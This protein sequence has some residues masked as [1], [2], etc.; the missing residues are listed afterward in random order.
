MR[1][2]MHNIF[3]IYALLLS[4]LKQVPIGYSFKFSLKVGVEESI[5]NVPCVS[6]QNKNTNN[7]ISEVGF[8]QLIQFV[9]CSQWCVHN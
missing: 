7:A 2:F 5:V 8:K 4:Y 9:I 6:L 1:I 3:I